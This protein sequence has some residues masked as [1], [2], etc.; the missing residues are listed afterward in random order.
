[1][2]ITTQPPAQKGVVKDPQTVGQHIRNKRIQ[3]QL[4]QKDVA[5][6]IG[7]SEDCITYWENG[8]S[9][10]QIQF[11]PKII[12]FLDY[13]PIEVDSATH[14]GKLLEYR[15]RQGLSQKRL[16]KLVGADANTIARWENGTS[17][18]RSK[19]KDMLDKLPSF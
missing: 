11:M 17:A 10:P 6:I 15:M 14:R 3:T 1:M 4:L 8:R 13:V 18:I 12:E 19:I 9:E 2:E 5:K 16:G 7:V